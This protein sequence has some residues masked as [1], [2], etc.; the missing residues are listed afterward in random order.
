MKKRIA[1]IGLYCLMMSFSL[2]C[3]NQTQQRTESANQR[4]SPTDTSLSTQT[5]R[6]KQELTELKPRKKKVLLDVPLVSQNPE[7]KYGCEVTSL[8]MVL[9]HAGIRVGKLELADRV[10]KDN[11]RLKTSK[12]GDITHWGDPNEGF[13][14]DMTG[15]KKGYAVYADPLE[16]LMEKYLPGR[17]VNL[18]GHPFQEVLA[19]LDEGKPV[20]TWTTGDYKKP[21]RWESW[22]HGSERITTPLDLHAV[23]LVGFEPEYVYLNDPLTAKKAVKVNKKQFMESW[24][25]LGSQAL[26][27]K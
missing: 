11:N 7:L 5:Q 1:I 24:H 12:S 27:Y 13:V 3:A 19:Q 21:D 4:E 9:K 8:S 14:G 16:E 10:K 25:A 18:T 23:V 26:S 22:K 6:K 15:K 20:V 17:T 2:G